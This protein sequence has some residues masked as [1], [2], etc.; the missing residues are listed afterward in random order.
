MWTPVYYVRTIPLPSSVEGVSVP[1]SDGSF[2][3]YLNARLPEALQKECLAHEVRHII[4]DHFYQ[5]AKCVACLEQEANSSSAAFP[6]APQKPAAPPEFLRLPNV[7]EKAPHGMIPY[8]SSLD[9]YKDYMFYMRHQYHR[10]RSM[11]SG[12]HAV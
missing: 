7:F 10:D 8:F 3:I 2:D 4:E 1:N 5:E 6:T 12:Q 11:Q 9:A